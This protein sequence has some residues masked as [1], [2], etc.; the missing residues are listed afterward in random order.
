MTDDSEHKMRR[1]STPIAADVE[2]HP[3]RGDEPCPRPGSSNS[4]LR[5]AVTAPEGEPATENNPNFVQDEV[6]RQDGETARDEPR[7]DDAAPGQPRGSQDDSSGDAS[8]N[9]KTLAFEL[10]DVVEDLKDK[11][12]LKDDEYLKLMDLGRSIFRAQDH[13]IMFTSQDKFIHY[14]QFVRNARCSM[15]CDRE[16]QLLRST[17]TARVSCLKRKR[18][19]TFF[20]AINHLGEI[21]TESGFQLIKEAALSLDYVLRHVTIEQC[22]V[23]TKRRATEGTVGEPE[24]AST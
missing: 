12:N 4:Q 3:Q 6:P 19:S 16:I 18:E 14:L 15:I 5:D 7:R 23:A 17:D 24:T 2:H 10:T 1:N 20:Q 8:R 22:N 13:G 9:C 21:N 11:Y